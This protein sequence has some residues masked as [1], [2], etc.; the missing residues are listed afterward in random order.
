MDFLRSQQILIFKY[1]L[2]RE[3]L[4]YPYLSVCY[5]V[6]TFATNFCG[7][8]RLMEFLM[9][10]EE[11]TEKVISCF[12]DVYN[13]LGFGFLE[14]VYENALVIKLKELG[15]DTV[16]QMPINVHFEGK[17]VGSYYA[18]VVVDDKVIVEI[19]AID[20]LH[21]EHSAQLINYLKST[22]MEVGLLMNFGP[23]PEFIRK[24]FTNDFKKQ[25]N[26]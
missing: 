11:I 22:R 17:I 12:Y 23:E 25:I 26:P 9:L 4:F 14:K 13:I 18:D 5:Y 21:K 1:E 16:Q 24:I 15:F 20:K 3:N 8:N 6:K 19:K 10:H 2:I 7:C